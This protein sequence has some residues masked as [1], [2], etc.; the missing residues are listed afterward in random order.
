MNLKKLLTIAAVLTAAHLSTFAEDP[1][2]AEWAQTEKAAI[3]KINRASLITIAKGAPDSYVKLFAEVKPDYKSS[4]LELTRIAALTQFLA[5]CGNMKECNKYADALVQAAKAS[6]APDVTCFF[7]DQL[8]WCA[9]PQQAKAIKSF[10][11]SEQEGVAALAAIAAFA[12]ERNFDSQRVVDK[13]TPYAE[14][15]EKISKLKS[16]QKLKALLAGFANEDLKIA[17]LAMREASELDIQSQIAGLESRK[18]A[19]INKRRIAAGKEETKVWALKLEETSDP[20]RQ[21]M[22]LDMLGTR[23]NPAA[24]STLQKYIG[25]ADTGTSQAAQTAMLKI[26]PEAF[27]K[28]LP[29]V[30]KNLPGSHTAIMKKSLLCVPVEL[31]E[32]G[33]IEDYS[34]YSQ[35]GK[36]AT[37]E[38]LQVRRSQK[39]VELALTAI[40]SSAAEESKNG[41]RL[42]RDCAGPDHAEILIKHLMKAR[43]GHAGDAGSAVVGA[44]ERDTT[45]T[46]VELLEEAWENKK[47][48]DQAVALLSTF[49][50][51]GD[52]KL[53]P[54]TEEALKDSDDEEVATAAARAL[55]DWENNDSINT[56]LKIA[57]TSDNN[58]QRVLAQRGIEKKLSAKGVDKAPYKKAWQKISSGA[59]DEEMKKKLDSFFAK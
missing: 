5:S 24:I 43:H 54:L 50:R 25:Y 48:A 52:K 39:G 20:V 51:I 59:G 17:G 41:F 38:T 31:V 35:A 14:Y 1:S 10:E 8:R 19:G 22:L 3:D 36:D 46:Y 44:A 23:G 9:T 33:L 42:L 47:N 49:G 21:V 57:Y 28:A 40:N 15:S 37:M 6:T 29:P 4:P 58:K 11:S 53:L 13:K 45:G 2:A 30:L 55:A 27:V 12:A 34:T 18:A 7:I 56:L 26:D 32:E 16:S